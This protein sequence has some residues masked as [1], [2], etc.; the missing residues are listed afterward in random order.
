MNSY[1][2]Y[3][4]PQLNAS[5]IKQGAD[6]GYLIKILLQNINNSVQTSLCYHIH[7]YPMGHNKPMMLIEGLAMW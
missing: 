4:N 1:Q 3:S 2:I 6:D 7:A 5:R